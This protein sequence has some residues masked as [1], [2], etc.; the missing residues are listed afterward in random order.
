MGSGG[1]AGATTSTTMQTPSSFSSPSMRDKPAGFGDG[2]TTVSKGNVKPITAIDAEVVG[3]EV[4]D[5]VV[6]TPE[7]TTAPQTTTSNKVR[8]KKGKKRKN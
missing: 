7:D 8:G 2:S 5:E 6:K 1:T 4:E 3:T